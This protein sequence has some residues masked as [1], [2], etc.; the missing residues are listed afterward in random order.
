MDKP[1][2]GFAGL[3]IM[4]SRM[5][6]RYLDAGYPLAVW[7]R[8]ASRAQ[9][10]VAA[11]AV[12]AADPAALAGRSDVVCLNL[13]DP[14]A[15]TAT[16]EAMRPGLRAGVTVI[17]FSTVSPAAARAAAA[18][19]AELGVGYLEAPVT[20]SKGG[21][22]QGTLLIMA[23]GDPQLFERCREL[24]AV[25]GSRA[26]YC[27]LTGAGSRVKLIGNNLIAHM[28][29]GLAQGL[30]VAREAGLDGNLVLDVVRASGF[31]S[32]YYDFKGKQILQRD[33]DTHFSLDLLHKD[34][35]LLLDEA[36]P[37]RVPL[38]GVA[39]ML[40]VVQAARARGWGAEDI[41]AVAKLFEV[42]H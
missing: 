2:I 24:L 20:G 28:L 35:A 21:A 9:P 3:G 15:V 23:A 40:E 31:S 27:G 4:G 17:D 34:L 13:A 36:G 14:P 32:P 19:L 6:R 30:A 8:T 39:T 33:F 25:V 5:A 16:L 38:P 12:E 41:A 10:L 37:S 11:G 29:V 22:A 26:I 1:R 18:R 7:N 42:G